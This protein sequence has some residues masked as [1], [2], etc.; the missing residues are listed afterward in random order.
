MFLPEGY[1]SVDFETALI[2]FRS[3]SILLKFSFRLCLYVHTVLGGF[4]I[5][6]TPLERRPEFLTFVHLN[7]LC[8]FLYILALSERPL[9]HNQ[10]RERDRLIQYHF[11][12]G[13]SW[14]SIISVK[15]NQDSSDL[16]IM[17]QVSLKDR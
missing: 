10:N 2:L 6:K 11:C 16:L 8:R 5:K 1:E 7:K 3:S 12:R 17:F 9:I 4:P 14:F 13:D 15:E